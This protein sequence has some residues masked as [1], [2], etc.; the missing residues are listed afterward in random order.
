[1]LAGNLGK[2]GGGRRSPRGEAGPKAGFICAALLG[3]FVF[4]QV[5]V[6]L[7]HLEHSGK[8]P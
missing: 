3:D 4:S 6:S 1:M 8:A 7:V 5:L 2:A